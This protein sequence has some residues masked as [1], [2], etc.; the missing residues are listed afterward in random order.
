MDMTYKKDFEK[1]IEKVGTIV[2]NPDLYMYLS[3][4]DNLKTNSKSI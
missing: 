4:Y 3:G 2:E 1:A